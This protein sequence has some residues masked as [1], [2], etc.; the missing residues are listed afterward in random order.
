LDELGSIP[1]SF[2]DWR[3]AIV[4]LREA[5]NL[6]EQVQADDTNSTAAKKLQAIVNRKL[7]ELCLSAAFEF[8]V[9]PR[10]KAALHFVPRTLGGAMWLQLAQAIAGNKNYRACEA[11]GRYFEL[12]LEGA[13]TSRHY[14]SD[15]CRSKA[16]RRR[17]RQGLQLHVQGKS[18][19]EM[20]D[21]FKS[22]PKMV[23]TMVNQ[24]KERH[25]GTKISPTR[26]RR[27]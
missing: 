10:R 2:E 12:S 18:L 3:D 16:Y 1:Q 20:E 21:E 14:C 6:W 7:G 4:K 26:T 5:I 22:D 15:A 11:C 25:H 19:Q 24:Q 9:R 8:S 27:R 23:K 13:R 17:K